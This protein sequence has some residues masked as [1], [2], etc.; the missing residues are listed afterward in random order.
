L[1]ETPP[2]G[3]ELPNKRGG[4]PKKTH[5]K[6]GGFSKKSYME[7]H[8]TQ[9]SRGKL[10]EDQKTGKKEMGDKPFYSLNKKTWVPNL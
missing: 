7:R 1:G 9:S 2:K 3:L 6:D 5:E 8:F 4:A 10:K